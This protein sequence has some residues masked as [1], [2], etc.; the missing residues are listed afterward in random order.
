MVLG[1]GLRQGSGSPWLLVRGIYD[2]VLSGV[3]LDGFISV[4]RIPTVIS[5][6]LVLWDSSGRRLD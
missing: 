4:I 6:L 2:C 5:C 1:A 3:Y